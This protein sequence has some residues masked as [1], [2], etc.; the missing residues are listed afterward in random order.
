MKKILGLILLAVLMTSCYK[1]Y[2]QDYP[3]TAIYFPYQYDVRTVVVGEGMSIKVGATL[4]GAINNVVDR[5]VYYTLD[6]TLITPAI[7][8]S[9][10]SSSLVYIKNTMANTATL[11]AMPTSY[12]TLSNT[13]QM[14]IHKS[15]NEGDVTLTVDSTKFLA[16]RLTL[17]GN[18]C[19][20]F[21]ITS[22][23]SD[24]LVKA[25]RSNVVCIKYENMLFGNYWHGV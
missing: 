19:V 15:Q 11:L 22:A 4:G 23:M 3:Y 17:N 2:V 12:Y 1:N 14:I 21:W 13:S 9:M 5:T 18:Y 20:P 10:K 8:A 7:L 25:M 24:S 6:N 16:D